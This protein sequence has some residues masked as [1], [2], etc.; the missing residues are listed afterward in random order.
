[1]KQIRPNEN[2]LRNQQDQEAVNNRVPLLRDYITGYL[3][4]AA[5]FFLPGLHHFYLGNTWRGVKYLCTGNE[6]VAGWVLDLF[7]L[8]V[9]IQKSVQEKGHVLGLLYCR[10][11]ATNPCCCC[12][13]PCCPKPVVDVARNNGNVYD[14][15]DADLDQPVVTHQPGSP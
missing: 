3:V 1:M 12:L 14:E 2:D 9:L 11:C 13:W 4:W 8:H 10:C 7:E 5:A 15:D 6:V